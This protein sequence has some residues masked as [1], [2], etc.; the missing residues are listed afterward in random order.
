MQFIGLV[1]IFVVFIGSCGYAPEI[2]SL[3]ISVV[4]CSLS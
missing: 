4:Y 3:K 1:F 2:I